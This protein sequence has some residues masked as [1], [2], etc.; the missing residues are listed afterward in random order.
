MPVTADYTQSFNYTTLAGGAAAGTAYAFITKA[1]HIH[2]VYQ[3]GA[4]GG[5]FFAGKRGINIHTPPAIDD[6]M[7]VVRV[8]WDEYGELNKWNGDMSE[9]HFVRASFGNRGAVGL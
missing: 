7:S 1:A 6:L 8:A 2:P 3:L 4:R 5:N 9:I